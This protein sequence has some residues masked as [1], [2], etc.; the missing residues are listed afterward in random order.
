MRTVGA[1]LGV[2]Y[3]VEGSVRKMDDV[4]RVNVQLIATE[5][6]VHLWADRFHQPLKSLST[7]Q[8]EIVRR[9]SQTLNVAVVDTEICPQQAGAADKPRRIRPDPAC[10]VH[11][12][13]PDGSA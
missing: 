7:G 3:V 11:W 12:A 8:E 13:P 10:T 5:T 9:I 6:G 1:D 4:L 2:R